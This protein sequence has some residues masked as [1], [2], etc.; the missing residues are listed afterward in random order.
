MA[1]SMSKADGVTILT[2]ATDPTSSCPPLCQILG[3]LCYSPTC[4]SVS[5][6][7]GRFMGTSQT[8]LGALHIMTGLLNIGLGVILMCTGPFSSWEMDSSGY[9]YWL[10]TLFILFGIVCILSERFPSPCLVIVNVILNLS[11]IGFAIA[12]IVLY[13]INIS[14]IF[15]WNI[16]RVDDSYNWSQ[17]TTR[18]L[19]GNEQQYLQRCL[20]GKALL[21]ML[22]RSINGMAIVL[23]VL[24]LCLVISSSVLA[25]KS[26]C[27]HGNGEP[28]HDPQS[29]DEPEGG[30]KQIPEEE[31]VA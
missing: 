3:G 11:G 6:R 17:T 13:A 8:V 25:I 22:L 1:I 24:E 20:E 9:P 12:G 2:L 7:L 14:D 16:C 21:L 4:C 26:L 10:G 31:V 18:S 19:S 15:L 29:R 5:R 28:H 23:C 30:Y 27:R